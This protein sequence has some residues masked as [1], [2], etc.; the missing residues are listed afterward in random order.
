MQVPARLRFPDGLDAAAFLREHWQE[1][2][3]AM[4]AALAGLSLD[5]DADELA[6]LA[7]EPDVESRLVLRRGEGDWRLEDGPFDPG[8]LRELGNTD[9]TLLVQD[10]EKH[11]PALSA[12]LEPF[13]FL[14]GWRIDDLMFS[15]AVPGGSVGPH[16]DA[17]DVFLVQVSG[18]RRWE[19]GAA[20]GP[21]SARS[22]G[23]LSLLDGMQ[24]VET[25]DA[26]PGDVLYLPP[27]VPHHGVATEPCITCS[28]G[29]RAASLPEMVRALA[30][31][32][33][34][35][36]FYRD[37]DLS[38]EEADAGRI[39][40]PAVERARALL[41]PAL[42]EALAA[43]P[44]DWFGR[45]ATE[46]KPWLA[47]ESH[48]DPV[49][50]EDFRHLVAAD[51]RLLRHGMSRWAC[52]TGPPARLY[53]DGEALDVPERLAGLCELLAGREALEADR[54]KDYLGDEEAIGLLYR[55]Y[56]S[57]SLWFRSE[58]EDASDA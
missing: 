35:D 23:G 55:L 31:A 42:E 58:F 53:V 14:P 57:G 11:L 1:A 19:I 52:W 48:P 5:L 2:P 47:P 43:E 25:F 17:Y 39:R 44:P 15:Y 37:P 40:A 50:R 41:A 7:C 24:V 22:D 54:L 36:L 20:A 27:G 34:A 29:F 28:V 18:T 45:L 16:L 3:L 9:W 49:T 51:D 21:H 32:V 33:P 12:L 6:G 30:T 4:P 26:G 10:V 38:P 56:R 13:A 46:P 8:R